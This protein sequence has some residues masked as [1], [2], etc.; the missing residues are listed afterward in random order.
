MISFSVFLYVVKPAFIPKQ[1]IFAYNKWP[2]NFLFRCLHFHCQ[3]ITAYLGNY[4]N[5]SSFA[6]GRTFIMLLIKNYKERISIWISC[7]QLILVPTHP[8]CPGQ[9]P[10][11]RK[12]VVCVCVCVSCVQNTV[13]CLFLFED[14]AQLPLSTFYKN[15]SAHSVIVSQSLWY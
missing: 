10:E 13:C 7:V 14:N 6:F 5:T 3:Q 11:S 2:Q 4:L 8:G 9:N 12:M 1:H 15:I